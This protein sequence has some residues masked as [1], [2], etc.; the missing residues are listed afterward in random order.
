NSSAFSPL[1]Q[2]FGVPLGYFGLFLGGLVCLGTLFPSLAFERT[3][4]FL[5]WVNAVGVIGLALYSVIATH[6][7]CL[8]CSGYY[9]FS[10]ISFVL[11]WMFGADGDDPSLLRRFAQPS[12][13]YLAVFAV[14]VATGA[15]AF[16]EYHQQKKEAQSGSAAARV[17][18]QYF[19][20]PEVKNPSVVSPY[21]SV[22]GTGRFEDAPIRVVEYADFLCP[23]CL[24]LSKQIEQLKQEFNGKLNIAF[25]F[26]PLEAKCNTVVAKDLHPGACEMTYI[27]AAIGPEK[28]PAVHDEIFA[29]FTSAKRNP[30]WRRDMARRYHVESAIADPALQQQVGQIIATG[31]E[32]E[33]TSDKFAHG[34]RSTPTLII[35]N[36]MVIGTF[37]SEQLR[38]IFQALV[39]RSEQH[40]FMENWQDSK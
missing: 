5:A 13:K 33:K 24:Y 19:N 32:Y 4:K 12:L 26:F 16:R 22:R 29:N 10:L 34:I 6:T 2:V 14:L 28:F 23:D 38:A 11:F 18:E 35:N 20:L 36:R 15:Y 8:L 25:Q 1:A 9:V 27:A 3:N 17:V 40:K 31:S 37:P 30:A 39:A 21:W 7:L